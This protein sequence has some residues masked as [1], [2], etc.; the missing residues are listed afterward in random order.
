MEEEQFRTER[1]RATWESRE[2]GEEREWKDGEE[3]LWRDGE[4]IGIWRRLVK[5]FCRWAVQKGIVW[6]N[7]GLK[8]GQVL[9]K[10]KNG[11]SGEISLH[12]THSATCL[13]IAAT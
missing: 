11:R 4:R 5:Y 6:A 8:F 3:R 12:F 1:R 7:T 9:V 10:S 2:G 13:L